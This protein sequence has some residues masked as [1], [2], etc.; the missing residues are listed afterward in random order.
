MAQFN[1]IGI[2]NWFKP[3]QNSLLPDYFKFEE[4]QKTIVPPQNKLIIGENLLPFDI[5]DIDGQN[6]MLACGYTH[7]NYNLTRP[8]DGAYPPKNKQCK[9]ISDPSWLNMA[10]G[11]NPKYWHFNDVLNDADQTQILILNFEAAGYGMVYNEAMRKK[12]AEGIDA[13][14]QKKSILGMWAQ[15]LVKPNPFYGPDGTKNYYSAKKMANHYQNPTLA[16]INGFVNNTKCQL[17]IP[18]HYPIKEQSSQIYQLMHAHE[19][20]KLINP[21]IKNIPSIWISEET[22]DEWPQ[23]VAAITQKR[24]KVKEVYVKPQA[25]A[26]RVFSDALWTTMVMDGFYHFE[27]PGIGAIDDPS[28]LGNDGEYA[29]N[30][31]VRKK[32]TKVYY[33]KKYFGFYNYVFLALNI[34][35]KEPVKSILEAETTWLT[36]IFKVLGKHTKFIAETEKYPSFCELNKEPLIRFKYSKDYKKVLIIA[37]NPFNMGLQEV[38]VKDQKNS[39]EIKLNLK[40]GWP[41]IGIVEL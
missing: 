21:N 17:S 32:T 39:W 18:F 40:G 8:I 35:S 28:Y 12:L 19:I 26:S 14:A 5:K 24:G 10:D 33:P 4:A 30:A 37:Q 13:V 3:P 16:D 27:W 15:G 41:T 38:F 25:S 9:L 34:I 11:T 6:P 29:G 36:P 1:E 7:I 31:R 2:P 22:V 20:G 23:Q